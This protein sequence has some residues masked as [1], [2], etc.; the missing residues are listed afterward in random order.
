[1]ADRRHSRA[2]LRQEAHSLT[3]REWAIL[4][5]PQTPGREHTARGETANHRDEPAVSSGTQGRR[6]GAYVSP[7]GRN[8]PRR[9][10][11]GLGGGRQLDRKR[12]EHNQPRRRAQA[13]RVERRGGQGWR[14]GSG[15]SVQS[16]RAR[17]QSCP[18]APAPGTERWR[19]FGRGGGSPVCLS[20]RSN[21]GLGAGDRRT[22]NTSFCVSEAAGRVGGREGRGSRSLLG[23]TVPCPLPPLHCCCVGSNPPLTTSVKTQVGARPTAHRYT[24][25]CISYA[26]D[27]GPTLP[28]WL[29]PG[30]HREGGPGVPA[31]ISKRDFANVRAN[32]AGLGLTRAARARRGSQEAA[33]PVPVQREDF[34][35]GGTAL[36]TRTRRDEARGA[37]VGCGEQTAG[38]EKAGRE[39]GRRRSPKEETRLLRPPGRVGKSHPPRKEARRERRRAWTPAAQPREPRP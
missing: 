37:G 15:S 26:L 16:L 27:K 24:K 12:R 14:A 25:G 28:R 13:G 5:R 34:L 4:A 17:S 10:H 38:A 7:G 11:T 29:L 31:P 6:G 18:R 36:Q 33:P 35:G 30:S 32:A 23:V 2:H 20:E 22:R 19:G 9:C 39:Q 8:Q 3:P 1:M 21:T